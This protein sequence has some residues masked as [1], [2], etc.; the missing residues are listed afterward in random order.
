MHIL[1]HSDKICL[2]HWIIASKKLT[3]CHFTHIG[4]IAESSK[5]TPVNCSDSTDIVPGNRNT[6]AK[7]LWSQRKVPWSI[8]FQ[9]KGELRGK[10]SWKGKKKKKRCPHTMPPKNSHNYYTYIET[11]S[12]VSYYSNKLKNKSLY[13]YMYRY[14]K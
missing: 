4:V 12:W 8:H 2:S 13:I 14:M 9:A 1:K 10:W 5:G 11:T 3:A 6:N 7:S